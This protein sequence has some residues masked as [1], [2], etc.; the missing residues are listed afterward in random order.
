M[1]NSMILVGCG[2]M[3]RA[4]LE[5]WLDQG[6]LRSD[7]I[8]VVEPAVAL[9]ARPKELGCSVISDVSQL[10][11][12]LRPDFIIFA[13]KPQLFGE[14]VPNYRNFCPQSTFI[15]I[16]AGIASA[17]FE[18]ALGSE[19]ALIRVMPN[20]PAS[21]GEGA[22]AFCDNGRVTRAALDFVEKLLSVNGAVVRVREEQ[23]DA[24]TGLSGSGSAY[25]FHL[26]ECLTQAGVEVGLEP[27]TALNLAR[28]TV[29]GAGILATT[30]NLPPATL[31]EQVTSP[32]GTTEAGLRVLMQEGRM[33][34]IFSE[35]VRA[36]RDRSVELG[37]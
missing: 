6:I 7:N 10:P 11:Q 27:E 9:H 30:T 13:I 14:V 33:Q 23:M 34:K 5:G 8:H 21:I 29:K 35:C 3:G 25:V 36:A 15:S 32:N 20:M 17:K 37:E 4:M 19:A 24:V 16:L 2:N 1:N 18:Q 22:M 31:R 12:D 28:Q 26:I